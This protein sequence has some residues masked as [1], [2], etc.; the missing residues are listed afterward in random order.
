M[1]DVTEL[2]YVLEDLDHVSSQASLF[3]REEVKS[4]ESFLGQGSQER[5]HLRSTSLDSF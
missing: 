1:V 5:N 2:F 4:P 3:Q